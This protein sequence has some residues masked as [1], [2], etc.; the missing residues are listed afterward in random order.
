MYIQADC[1]LC[2]KFTYV[3]SPSISTSHVYTIFKYICIHYALKIYLYTLPL[4][5]IDIFIY[6]YLLGRFQ[7]KLY[8][9]LYM[10]VVNIV[11]IL[12]ANHRIGG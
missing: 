5:N 7:F 3:K 10:F 12:S 4:L 2:Y 11:L 6:I 9:L 8:K 1:L